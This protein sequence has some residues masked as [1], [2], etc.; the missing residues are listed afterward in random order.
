MKIFYTLTSSGG[1]LE[2]QVAQKESWL[3][4]QDY[5]YA[6]DIE[7][8]DNVKLSATNNHRSAEQKQL[9]SLKYLYQNKN[10]YDWYFFGDDDTFVNTENLVNFLKELPVEISSCGSVLTAPHLCEWPYY[11]GGA[12]FVLRKDVMNDLSKWTDFP[13]SGLSDISIGKLMYGKYTLS[14]YTDKFCGQNPFGGS[15]AAINPN[16]PHSEEKIKSNI[17]YHYVNAEE[18]KKLYDMVNV[19]YK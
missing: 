11:S 15:C 5:V 9:N 8:E 12:G 7:N 3:K 19:I 2:R 10:N 14:D 17:S 13:N 6:S 1:L 16:A 4:K 18:M